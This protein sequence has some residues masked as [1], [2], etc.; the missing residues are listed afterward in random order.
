MVW[1]AESAE[2]QWNVYRHGAYQGNQ[3]RVVEYGTESVRDGVT[4]LAT[5]V[6]TSRSLGSC[7][8]ANTSR[9][10]ELL[11]E[12]L[13]TLGILRLVRVDFGVDSFEE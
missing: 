3:V 10:R 1:I 12:A 11:E 2:G 5:F 7:V 13:H 6:N 8:T 9:E 4:K